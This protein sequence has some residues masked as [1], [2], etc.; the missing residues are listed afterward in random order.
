VLGRLGCSRFSVVQDAL[1]AISQSHRRV[2]KLC[3]YRIRALRLGTLS[4]IWI[5]VE[6]VD[7]NCIAVHSAES[8]P[9]L[10]RENLQQ[11]TQRSILCQLHKMER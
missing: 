9:I 2:F 6:S 1:A 11:P 4:G 8:V 5:S 10:P 7:C 3:F